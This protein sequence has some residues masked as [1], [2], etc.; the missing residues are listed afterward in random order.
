PDAP[1]IEEWVSDDEEQDESPI[2]VEKKTIV[3]TIPK[4][5]VVKSKQQEK[6]VRNAEMYRSQKPRGN[7][8]NWNNL[9]SQQLGSDFVMIKKACYNVLPSSK[10]KLCFKSSLNENWNKSS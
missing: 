5:N 2:V 9:K 6:P 10:K 7:Q 1:I 3:P 4:V 8:R